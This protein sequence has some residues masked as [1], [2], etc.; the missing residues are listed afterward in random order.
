VV[1]ANLVP[2][3][4]QDG[5]RFWRGQL[6]CGEERTD[7]HVLVPPHEAPAPFVLC[8]PILAGGQDLMWMVATSLAERGHIVAWSGRVASALR[9]GQRGPDLERLLRRTVIHNRMLLAWARRQPQVDD[10]RLGAVGISMGGIVGGILLAVEPSLCGAALCL[11]GGDLADLLM[12]SAEARAQ[13]W[14]EWRRSADGL[15]GS[16]LRREVALHV[17]SDPAALGPYVATDR[18]L[19]L[20]AM[21]D[22]VVPARSQR[23]LWESF[24]RPQRRLLP[25]GH[26]TSAVA[27]AAVLAAV[28]EFLGERFA[29]VAGDQPKAAAV[30]GS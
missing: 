28:D 15:L 4:Q 1:E 16:Q 25:V 14:R 6:E 13:S 20:S 2:L 19:L 21:F 27:F 11:S 8:L 18:V 10:R 12:V 9:P 3:G 29:A 24:G 22:E 26:Y 5:V 30:A 7:F 17:R 23:V